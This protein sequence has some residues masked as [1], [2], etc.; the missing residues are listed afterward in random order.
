ML[1]IILQGRPE[2]I[3]EFDMYNLATMTLSPD[4]VRA[5]TA[6][7]A[8]IPPLLGLTQQQLQVGTTRVCSRAR[9][10]AAVC[11]SGACEP[12]SVPPATPPM[13]WLRG[14]SAL[15]KGGVAA[16]GFHATSR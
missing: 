10:Q 1:A 7:R 3:A 16:T 6:R 9:Q 4:N 2:L 12:C 5:A 15:A 13:S 14:T 8:A 11:T